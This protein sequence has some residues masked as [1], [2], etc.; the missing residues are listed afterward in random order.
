MKQKQHT[1]NRRRFFQST[2]ITAIS[3]GTM[4][5]FPFSS[6]A[7]PYSDDN[8]NIIGPMEGYSPQ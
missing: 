3:A 8:I 2:A 6:Y 5:L 4:S 7:H 1:I